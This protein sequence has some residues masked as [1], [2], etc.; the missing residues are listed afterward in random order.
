MQE[1]GPHVR[2][3]EIRNS[4]W[5]RGLAKKLSR[6]N[7]NAIFRQTYMPR[8]YLRPPVTWF[9][10]TNHNQTKGQMET[11]YNQRNTHLILK[12]CPRTNLLHDTGQI[13]EIKL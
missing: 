2:A 8:E 3:S 7:A 13:N 12:H 6:K 9:T 4:A 11:R 10:K 1:Q 5:P